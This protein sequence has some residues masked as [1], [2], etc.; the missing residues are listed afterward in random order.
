M[1]SKKYTAAAES[2]I[3]ALV[4]R[5]G[6]VVG[7]ISLSL[8]LLRA[9]GGIFG[10]RVGPIGVLGLGDFG[11][12]YAQL[13]PDHDQMPGGEPSAPQIQGHRVTGLGVHC[14]Y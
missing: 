6:H 10:E 7:Y 5:W 4:G 12:P 11:D 9:M 14:N 1:V 2:L 8:R 13:L 3:A